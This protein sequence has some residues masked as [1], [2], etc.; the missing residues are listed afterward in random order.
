[1]LECASASPLLLWS[2]IMRSN[3]Q[4]TTYSPL[5]VWVVHAAVGLCWDPIKVCLVS[6]R[7]ERSLACVIMRSVRGLSQTTIEA[8]GRVSN[9]SRW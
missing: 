4:L 3:F 1:M 6:W 7:R 9:L 8:F 2:Q 5:Q